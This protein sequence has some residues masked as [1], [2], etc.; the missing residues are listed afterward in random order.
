M[1]SPIQLRLS[2]HNNQEL[3]DTHA[4]EVDDDHPQ[5]PPSQEVMLQYIRS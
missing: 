5:P 3:Q 4:D 2:P 1:T